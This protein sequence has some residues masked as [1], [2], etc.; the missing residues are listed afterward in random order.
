MTR[1]CVAAGLVLLLL[2]GLTTGS[3]PAAGEPQPVDRG[4]IDEI[5]DRSTIREE[6]AGPALASYLGY[7]VVRAATAIVGPA[8]ERAASFAE[9]PFW[10]L[11]ALSVLAVGLAIWMLVR[12]LIGRRTRVAARGAT[13]IEAETGPTI[14]RTP[15]EWLAQHQRALREGDVT[16]ALGSLW[17]WVA[18]VVAPPGL[19]GSWTSRDLARAVT[20]DGL[21]RGLR[22][23]DELAFGG[24]AAAESDIARLHASLTEEL[25]AS[26]A[27]VGPLSGA[28]A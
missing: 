5:Y 16:A 4:L 3:R 24:G 19:D 26:S 22:R 28:S 1:V 20:R 25:L 15:E 6:E 8:A 10:V 27:E 9:I 23:L 12:G 14:E 21:I 11:I 2:A 13:E 18:T 17:W 7:L